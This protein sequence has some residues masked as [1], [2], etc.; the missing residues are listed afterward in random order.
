M[1][2]PRAM[3][4]MFSALRRLGR[5]SQLAVYEDEG[6]VIYEWEQKRAIDATERL[7]DFLRR[8]LAM[9]RDRSSGERAKTTPHP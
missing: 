7:L 5:D 4:M 6:H 2:R 3:E 8:R 1:S 9:S